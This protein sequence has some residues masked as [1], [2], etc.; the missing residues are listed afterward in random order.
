MDTRQPF[1]PILAVLSQ[2][3]AKDELPPIR[4]IPGIEPLSARFSPYV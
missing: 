1:R 2:R 4:K 3:L